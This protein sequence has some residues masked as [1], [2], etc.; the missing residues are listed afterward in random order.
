M[1]NYGM[2]Y[3]YEKINI[4]AGTEFPSTV[5]L[6][7]NTS[8]L[9]WSR[10]LYQR[11]ASVFE[12]EVPWKGDKMDF[13]VYCLFRLGFIVVTDL[14]EY[15]LIWQPCTVSGYNLY[16]QPTKALISNPA[17]RRGSR[18]IQLGKTGELIR[19]TPDYCGVFDVISRYAQQLANL[20]NSV[21]MA[22]TNSKIAWILGAANKSAAATIK[23]ALDLINQ[24]NPAVVFDY[25]K[26]LAGNPNTGEDP[27][28]LIDLEVKKNY[29]LTDLLKDFQ[30]ILN[31]FDAEVGIPT[32][33]Y[34]KA[35]RM[36]NS[37]ANSRMIDS[38]ARVLT[39]L[40]CLNSSADRVNA[41]YPAANISFSLTYDQQQIF[42]S[43]VVS[44][45][46]S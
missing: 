42:E 43:E 25:K 11:A 29:I 8:V 21:N 30:T 1:I 33:P 45:G 5:K 38:Q 37:E 10:S 39:W 31:N 24:G 20:D 35:E 23:K 16:Y 2:P 9:Y 26:L 28:K 40:E 18:K 19:L 22:I 41:L 32:I 14:P 4:A 44:D 12:W 27:W 7:N 17:I 34:Q 3:G 6:F 13:M 36:V 46:N 15:G